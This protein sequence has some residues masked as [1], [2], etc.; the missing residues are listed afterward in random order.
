MADDRSLR[1]KYAHWLILALLF[2]TMGVA[3]AE[4]ALEPLNRDRLDKGSDWDYR[5][6]GQN[7]LWLAY[8]DEL[9]VLRLRD[10]AGGEVAQVEE[11]KDAAPA[12]LAMAAGPEGVALLWR[13]KLPRKGLYLARVASG[14]KFKRDIGGDTEPLARFHA[15]E[16]GE[17]LHV[18]WYGEK[19]GE[20]TGQR[21]HLY[22][23]QMDT[24]SGDFTPVER[25]MPGYYPVWAADAPGNLLVF[26]WFK[27]EGGHQIQAQR[28][29]AG[30]ESF[31]APVKVTDSPP[32]TSIFRAFRS[33]G[34]WFVVWQGQY[35]EGLN[36]YLFEGAYSDD[37]GA[38]W[39]RFAVE[40]LRDYEIGSLDILANDEGNLLLAL[41]CVEKVP[42]EKKR[43]LCLVRSPDRGA[44]WTMTRPRP[45]AIRE[46]FNAK[47]PALVAGGAPG[48][49][50][51]LWED[52]R[53]IRSQVYASLSQDGGAT[54]VQ[55][56]IPLPQ[57]EGVNRGLARHVTP[58]YFRDGEFHLILEQAFDDSFAGKNLYP[59][60]FSP[61][62]LAGFAG[63]AVGG[64]VGQ[65]KSGTPEAV[66]TGTAVTSLPPLANPEKNAAF[67]EKEQPG[68]EETL[69]G[70]QA[71][72]APLSPAEA[73]LR[74]REKGFWEAMM[75]GRFDLAYNY[76]DPFFRARNSLDEYRANM[77]K[78]QYQ[79]FQIVGVRIDGPRALVK[80]KITA[81]I[82]PFKGKFGKVISQPK[83]EV[84]L[85]TI[86]VWVDGDW[87]REY[88][89]EYKE[90]RY[91][92]Y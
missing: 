79:D 35:G 2:L 6:D 9:R 1:L 16:Q 76:L 51:L 44:T 75:A 31:E 83:Q 21:Y 40:A 57:P 65:V 12:G 34:R 69:P 32:I 59:I 81:E 64:E 46:T 88:Y 37:L 14:E 54:W 29:L 4:N 27:T 74:E 41:T 87:Y 25:L 70:G 56:G 82:K 39:T 36:N 30:A 38:T 11:N 8:Y 10:P 63:A 62:A 17:K 48:E 7:R 26:S 92:R 24:R 78:I 85:D 20:P 89:S 50:L 67:T 19:A 23:R 22:Y 3:L 49:V 58:G 47:N 84:P 60:H 90:I 72:D 52:W 13:D 71:P 43:D 28:R 68:T 80:T 5:L 66:E 86:W 55:E 73:R 61:T 53:N 33:D 42:G 77:G 18:L 15:L 45:Q 91:T